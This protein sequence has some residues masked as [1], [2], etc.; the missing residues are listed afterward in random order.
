LHQRAKATIETDHKSELYR[1]LIT[2]RSEPML[3]KAL[4][5]VLSGELPSRQ[6]T[7]LL[8]DMAGGEFPELA[9]KFAQ[10]NLGAILEKLTA[11]DA[12]RYVPSLFQAFSDEE[13]AVELEEFVKVN[14][15]PTAMKAAAIGAEEVRFRAESK[16]RLL[17][18]LAAWMK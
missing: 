14:L 6:S 1:A 15:P 5:L 16:E 4:A 3:K 9:W 7:R 13:R 8:R 11:N 12:N 18:Q 10:K 2:T 17:P